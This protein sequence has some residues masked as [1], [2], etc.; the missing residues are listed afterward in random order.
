MEVRWDVFLIIVGTAIVTFIPRVLPLMVLSRFQLPEWATKWLS[1]V[2]ISVMAALVA[3]EIFKNGEN[4]S[5]S[6][7]HVEL[8]AAIPTFFIAIKTRSLLVT[9]LAGIIVVMVLRFLF[10]A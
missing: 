3:Q 1:Y 8:L 6:T 5:F 9:V 7:N 4:I 2:P 10:P